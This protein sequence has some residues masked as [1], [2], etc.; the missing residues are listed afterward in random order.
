MRGRTTLRTIYVPP[1]A[2]AGLG[3]SPVGLA[4]TPLMRE[5]I[6]VLTGFAYIDPCDPLQAALARPYWRSFPSPLLSI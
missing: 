2:C 6:L 4:V 1:D 5:L 3:A